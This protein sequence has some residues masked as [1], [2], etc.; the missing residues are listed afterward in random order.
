MNGIES[1]LLQLNLSWF[2]SKLLPYLLFPVVGLIV[3]L[4][5]IKFFTL[6]SKFKKIAVLILL[7]ISSF[8]AYFAYSPIYQGDFSNKATEIIFK[9]KYSEISPNK[10]TVLSIPNCPYCFAAMNKM[11]LLKK[12]NPAIEIEFKVCSSDPGSMRWYQDKGKDKIDVVLANDPKMMAKLADFSFPT[13]IIN[14]QNAKVLKWRNND[15]GVR[16]LDQIESM[17]LKAD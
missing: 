9:K 14:D 4:L 1:F 5:I 13:F 12:R 3:G 15:F 16:A 2:L 11:L 8:G 17:L 7:P 6:R 10:L